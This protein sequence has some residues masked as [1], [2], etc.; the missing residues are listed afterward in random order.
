[1]NKRVLVSLYGASSGFW[2]RIVRLA[3]RRP[4]ATILK[5]DSET[6]RSH[7][8]YRHSTLVRVTHWV[9]VICLTAL[10]MSGLQI[11]NA[12]PALYGGNASDF[13]RPVLEMKADYDEN[14]DQTIGVTTIFGRA[15]N[16]T[17]VLGLSSVDGEPVERGF[18][19]W[20][21]LPGYQDLAVGRRWHFFFAWLFVFNGLVYLASGF[22]NGHFRRDLVPRWQQWRHIG[23]SIIDHL[24]LRF[25]KG[26]EA[27][28][29]NILQQ[30]AYLLVVFFLLPVMV[31]AGL[32]LS[33]AI[34]A[35]VPGL[36]GLFGGRQSARTIHFI[37]ANA[38]VLFVLVHVIMVLL[39]GV[40]NNL[41]SMITGWYDIETPSESHESDS[42]N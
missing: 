37:V 5:E 16:T 2:S 15:F 42:S 24:R 25:P 34:D 19:S 20:I 4:I 7:W 1:M 18:P 33:P 41:R 3:G 35:A 28:R 12:H 30:L 26:E 11:F 6:E 32:T 10:L 9:N 21:T 40:W 17:G 38:L 29:Y 8:F 22:Y 14:K 36:V 13:K 31:L 39:S 23:R 27:R